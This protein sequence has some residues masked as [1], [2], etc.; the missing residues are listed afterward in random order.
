[1]ETSLPSPMT[2]RVY[3]SLPEG[4]CFYSTQTHYLKEAEVCGDTT[5]LIWAPILPGTDPSFLLGAPLG[6]KPVPKSDP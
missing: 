5:S 1:M 6:E 3:V 4:R 2:A